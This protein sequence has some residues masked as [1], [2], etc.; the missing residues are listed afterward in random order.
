MVAAAVLAPMPPPEQPVLF[1]MT[2][3]RMTAITESRLM[4]PGPPV[5]GPL[6]LLSPFVIVKPSIVTELIP[7]PLATTTELERWIV[8]TAE[9]WVV[10]AP[11][12]WVV[13]ASEV[14]VV[15]ASEVWVVSASEVWVVGAAI[16][17]PLPRTTVP[18]RWIVASW[19]ADPLLTTATGPVRPPSLTVSA[20]P[21]VDLRTSALAMTRFSRY[22]PGATSTV[23]PLGA[24][25]IAAWIVGNSCGTRSVAA[26]DPSMVHSAAPAAIERIATRSIGNLPSRKELLR[27]YPAPPAIVSN[28]KFSFADARHVNHGVASPRDGACNRIRSPADYVTREIT[29]CKCGVVPQGVVGSNTARARQFL[30]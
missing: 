9:V 21:P 10:S 12:L 7:S 27:S 16:L 2:L 5:P 30:Q 6:K 15:S 26:A 24:A 19:T 13:S 23:S 28:A 18:E 3:A 20:A 22:V 11:K 1:W 4:P 8:R 29:A 17:V 14:W 25:S